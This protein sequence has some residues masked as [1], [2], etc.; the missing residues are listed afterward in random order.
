MNEMPTTPLQAEAQT[1][2]PTALEQYGLKDNHL[3][4]S[5]ID[6]IP[7]IAENAFWKPLRFDVSV[8]RIWAMLWFKAPGMLGRHQHQGPV[9]GWVME[10]S[11]YYKE[12]DWVA[13]PGSIVSES[14]GGIHTLMTDEGTK[15]LFMIQGPLEFFGDDGTYFGSQNVFWFIEEYKRHCAAHGL[16]I[17]EKL[18]YC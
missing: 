10:G 6:W 16:P 13:T 18:F 11:W 4:E 7:Y 8:G 3:N 15:S 14:P 9:M 2:E 5:E 1:Q 17:N 12:Y